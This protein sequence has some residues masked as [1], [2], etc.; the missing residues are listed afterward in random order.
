MVVREGA[1]AGRP[2]FASRWRGLAGALPWRVA[3]L[4]F[5]MERPC[6][7]LAVAGCLPWLRDGEAFPGPCRGGAVRAR[8]A[9][10]L[11]HGLRP[12]GRHPAC[13][14]DGGNRPDRLPNPPRRAR[15]RAQPRRARGCRL[16]AGFGS[17]PRLRGAETTGSHGLR[18][19]RRIARI[20]RRPPERTERAPRGDRAERGS[21]VGERSRSGRLRRSAP[22]GAG[23]YRGAAS[24]G[25][26]GPRQGPE[27]E[28]IRQPSPREVLAFCFPPSTAEPTAARAEPRAAAAGPRVKARCRLRVGAEASRRGGRRIARIARRPPERTERAP[29]GDRA[30]RGSRVGERSRS[31]RLRRSAPH[32]AGGYRG[33]ASRGAE[34]PRQG[35]E[36]ER[37]RQPSPREVL[38]FCFPPPEGERIRQPSAKGARG[39]AARLPHFSLYAREPA[40]LSFPPKPR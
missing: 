24:R 39:P 38:A 37:I 10:P 21:R 13:G 9:R 32:G 3:S 34:G 4:G 31:G 18:G 26:E 16:C 15:N 30:E 11:R 28:R 5:A 6:R 19:D 27:D 2:L 35:P 23:G 36:D 20:A 7:G 25:A 33:A 22:H 12:L 1:S 17:A 14:R 40:V 29:R 8:C